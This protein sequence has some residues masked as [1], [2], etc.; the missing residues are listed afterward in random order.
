MTRRKREAEKRPRQAVSPPAAGGLRGWHYAAGCLLALL[1]LFQVYEPA[2]RGPFVFDDQ[3]LPFTDHQG[4][5][6]P[7]RNWISGLRP[8]LMASFWVN[9]RLSELE[10]VSY[11][12]L[13]VLLHL[14]NG[15]LVWVVV[16][17]LLK[18]AGTTGRLRELLAVFAAGLFLLHP[19]QTE[20]VA[21]VASR[22]ETLSV[23]FFSAALALF[24]CRRSEA[25]SWLVAAGVL[26]LFGA[27]VSTK[28][29]TAVLPA[30][31]LLTDYFW[32]PGFSLRGIGRNWRLYVPM[33][34]AGLLAGRWTLRVLHASDTAGFGVPEFTWQEYFFTQC[35][36]VWRYVR[37]FFLPYGQTIDYDLPISRTLFSH[38]AVFGLAGLV[39]VAATAFIWRRRYPLASYGVFV[40]LLLLAPTSSV[41]PILDPIAEHRLYLPMVGLLLVVLEFLRRWKISRRGLAA[42]LAGLLLIAGALSYQR[43]KVWGGSIALWEDAVAKSPGKGRAQSQLAFAYFVEGRCQEALQHYDA[44][45]RLMPVDYR[46]FYSR[47]L[48]YLCLGR[49]QEARTD[50]QA[51]AED[52]RQKLSREPWNRPARQILEMAESRLKQIP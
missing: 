44:T 4:A 32:N 21:Y 18:R 37:L 22:S 27:A 10:P 48:A 11:H 39:V 36:V 34:A 13:N 24:L 35:R 40:F 20:S 23:M 8:L 26:A 19:V 15:I 30:L 6:A 25:V 7:F 52:C 17:R 3:Y 33:A 16:R 31:L 43:N 12:V 51:A 5:R 46:L 41:I 42:T 47:A 38:G 1:A 9:Y 49:K 28:E 29:H 45:A 2:L 14:V 50:F